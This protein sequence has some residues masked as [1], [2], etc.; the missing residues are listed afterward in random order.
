MHESQHKQHTHNTCTQ[1]TQHMHT[2]N[3]QRERTT[4]TTHTSEHTTHTQVNTHMCTQHTHTSEHTQTNTLP[5]RR[6]LFQ[7]STDQVPISH[8]TLFQQLTGSQ[9][10]MHHFLYIH[11]A[12][13]LAFKYSLLKDVSIGEH[14][15]Y[16]FVQCLWECRFACT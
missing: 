4:H 9:C 13:V 7:T 6:T 8:S 11:S 10:H 15:V 12:P 5:F 1:H 16:C 3:T 2:T 14:H